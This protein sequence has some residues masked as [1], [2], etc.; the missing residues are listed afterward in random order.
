MK[1]TCPPVYHHNGPVA[2]HALG[3]MM[4]IS[5]KLVR[6]LGK[7]L[8]KIKKDSI[9]KPIQSTFCSFDQHFV[10]KLLQIDKWNFTLKNR[11]K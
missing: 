7:A 10:S 1:T 9:K 3:Q 4:Y 2:T 11:S 5:R 6:T 8:N